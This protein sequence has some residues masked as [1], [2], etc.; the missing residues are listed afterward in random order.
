[1]PPAAVV[2]DPAAALVH[3]VVAADLLGMGLGEPLR[4]L[5]AAGLLV[6]QRDDEQRARRR[7]P[8]AA[9]EGAGRGH[10]RRGLR[11]HVE[12]AA[13]PDEA[14]LELA[15]PRAMRPLGRRR[16]HGV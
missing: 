12:R 3:E 6:D 9:R 4:A 14:A 7:A 2:D 16:E 10:L 15:G 5:G 8:A 1:E 13:A 11:L